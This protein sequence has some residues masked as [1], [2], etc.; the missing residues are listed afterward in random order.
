MSKIVFSVDNRK[1]TA[2]EGESVL[3]AALRYRIDIP[4]FCTH[5]DLPIDANCRTCLVEI[6]PKGRVVTS[7]DLKPKPGMM[8]Y[9]NSPAVQKLRKENLELLL[10]DH[11]K[12]C[13][14][15]RRG[16]FCETA[17]LMKKYKVSGTKYRRADI[18]A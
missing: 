6:Q 2:N 3:Q 1:I 11:K 8:V 5:E 16:L 18:K 13:P 14:K 4:H 12:L 7:C 15:C 10:A 9:T 17:D